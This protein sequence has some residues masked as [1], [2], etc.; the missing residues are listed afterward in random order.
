MA[1]GA[2]GLS[3]FRLIRLSLIKGQAHL[4]TGRARLR[5]DVRV[6]GVLGD[7]ALDG[8]QPQAQTSAG[9][10]G[11]VEGL[12]DAGFEIRFDA[13]S[14]VPDLDKCHLSAEAGPQPGRSAVPPGVP[15]SFAER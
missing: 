15:R 14:R 6:A 12:E 2:L 8:V 3:R 11:S 5:L 4:E 1:G 10:L 7:D 13:R 9:R